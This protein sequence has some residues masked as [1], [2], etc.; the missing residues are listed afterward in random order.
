MY[1]GRLKHAQATFKVFRAEGR[2][3]D[4]I[5]V[6]FS[7]STCLSSRFFQYRTPVK[8]TLVFQPCAAQLFPGIFLIEY[9]LIAGN[10][11]KETWDF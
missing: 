3:T 10:K 1:I 4:N 6:F 11:R 8:E 5:K 2:I 7:N 9:L